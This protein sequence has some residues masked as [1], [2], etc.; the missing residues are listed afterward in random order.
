MTSSDY[1]HRDWREMGNNQCVLLLTYIAASSNRMEKR[2][3]RIPSAN[4]AVSAAPTH[5]GRTPPPHP[6]QTRQAMWDDPT[7]HGKLIQCCGNVVPAS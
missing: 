7:K 5:H 1:S 6:Y 2:Q 3:S 4:K